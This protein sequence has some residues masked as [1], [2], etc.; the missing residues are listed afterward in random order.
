VGDHA[1]EQGIAGNVEGHTQALPTASFL[2]W[3]GTG[4]SGA[5]NRAVATGQGGERMGRGSKAR[6]IPCP[7][8]V[9]TADRRAP[10]RKQRTGTERGTVVAPF[11][12]GLAGA[13]SHEEGAC[14]SAALL[15]HSKQHTNR[16][17]GRHDDAAAVRVCSN[18]WWCCTGWWCGPI[19]RMQGP[20]IGRRYLL[21]DLSQLINALA[22]VIGM[23]VS[24]FGSKVPPLANIHTCY[25]PQPPM[26]P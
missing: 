25:K 26:A 24:V 1:S 18:L 17:P 20:H 10:R 22:A 23:H 5:E 21:D 19:G 6:I 12:A 14:R 7:R 16:V 13:A 4:G 3:H 11:A 9:G 8:N 2:G 15:G